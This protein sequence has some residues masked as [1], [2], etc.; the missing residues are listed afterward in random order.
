M[1]RSEMLG[2][3]LAFDVTGDPAFPERAAFEAARELGV[4]VTTHAGVWGATNDNGIRLMHEHGFMTPETV[5]VHAATLSD[6]SYQRIAAT[7]GHASVSA[8]SEC[9]CGQGYPSSWAL[10]R[11][12]IPISLSV[13]TSV[14]FSA[15]PFAAMRATLSTDRAREHHEAHA[16]GETVTNVGLRAEQVVDWATRGG[17]RALGMDG[18]IGSL[19]AGKR[20][21]VVLVKNERSPAMFPILHPYGHLVFQAQRGD[22]HTVLVNGRVVKHAGALVGTDLGR[23]RRAIEH[24]IEHLRRS[25]GEEEWLAGM[26]PEIPDTKVLDNPYTYTDYAD[27]STHSA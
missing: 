1:K 27:A 13:D 6:D 18:I 11:H 2:F 15:D 26:H 22:V 14:W 8:E 19:E 16:R 9:S 4:A 24:T 12:G 21:D 20:A 17:A 25:L 10:R 7:G 3:Q 5:Y 23:A